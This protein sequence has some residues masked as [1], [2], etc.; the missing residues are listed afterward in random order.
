MLI[1]AD[2]GSVHHYV[3]FVSMKFAS[4]LFSVL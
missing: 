2:V 3:K 4:V 1:N